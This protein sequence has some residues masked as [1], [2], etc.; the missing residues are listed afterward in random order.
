MI[1]PASLL[2][3]DRLIYKGLRLSHCVVKKTFFPFRDSNTS[4]D[5]RDMFSHWLEFHAHELCSHHP[6]GLQL[7][8]LYALEDIRV[9]PL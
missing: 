9:D 5:E 2:I 8:T 1:A 4:E 6:K 3:E 7:S